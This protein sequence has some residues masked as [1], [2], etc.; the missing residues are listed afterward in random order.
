MENEITDETIKIVEKYSTMYDKNLK[1]RNFDK[2]FK[3]AFEL[4]QKM[5]DIGID[6][7]E[8]YK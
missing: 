2:C 1:Q 3:I 6:L 7:L 4:D 5:T 8:L